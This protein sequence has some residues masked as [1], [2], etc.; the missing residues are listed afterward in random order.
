MDGEA[1]LHPRC[2]ARLNAQNGEQGREQRPGLQ[3]L[4]G[5]GRC[6]R[7]CRMSPEVSSGGLFS[8]TM[9]LPTSAGA[10]GQKKKHGQ[11]AEKSPIISLT[12]NRRLKKRSEFAIS[13]LQKRRAELDA[14]GAREPWCLVP[15][16][17]DKRGPNYD[18]CGWRE[19]LS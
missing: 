12:E 5:A 14:L 19:D 1:G 10:G 6:W 17:S 4:A 7:Q 9:G 16:E 11:G 15:G 2:R 18:P 3:V 8:L 13:S